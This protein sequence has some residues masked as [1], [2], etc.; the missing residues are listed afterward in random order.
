MA[1]SGFGCV[2]IQERLLSGTVCGAFPTPRNP[3]SAAFIS[4]RKTL[5]LVILDS[6]GFVVNGKQS[7][8]SVQTAA[9]RH[10]EGSVTK[11]QGL[12]FAVVVAR[13]NE[14]VT[15]LLLE[16]AL[17]TFRKYSVNEEDIDVCNNH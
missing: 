5:D 3:P 16:G 2:K 17:E 1:L 15:K 11:A 6:R 10:L 8:S 9:V 12:R 13:F 4:P 14:I 7:S